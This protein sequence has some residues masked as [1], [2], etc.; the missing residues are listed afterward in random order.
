MGTGDRSEKIRTYNFPQD[1]L[2]DHRIGYTRHNLP[3][4][5]DGDVQD[6]IDA[7][8]TYYAAEALRERLSVSADSRAWTPLKLLGWTQT[9]F[10]GKG[11]DAPRLTAELLLAHALGCDRVRLYLDFDKPLGEPE[12]ARYR[13]LVKRRAGG[14]PTAYLTGVREFFGH[15]LAVDSA[16]AHPPARD[17]AA[18]RAGAGRAARG[19]R[20]ARPRRR[21]GR[22]GHRPLP[23]A[24]RRRASP[25]S[26]SLPER[27]RWPAPT[28][29]PWAPR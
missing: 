22:P 14:E 5:M 11:V 7:C 17:R 13:E 10:A 1:R 27:W 29:P 15:R 8:R 19:R 6:V 26:T 2:T 4:L 24:A 21:L 16:G 23:G 9:F 25:R 18:G 3:A 28:P 20:R 12:L